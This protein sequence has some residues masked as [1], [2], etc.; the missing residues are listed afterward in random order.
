MNALLDYCIK[1]NFLTAERA[2]ELE[3][4]AQQVKT[5]VYNILSALHILPEEEVWTRAAQSLHCEYINLKKHPIDEQIIKAVSVKIAHYY[6]IV[7]FE[8]DGRT[9]KI[10]INDPTHIT[11]IDDIRMILKKQMNKIR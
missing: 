5:P 3:Q 6:K 8:S 1:N 4:E 2:A 9:L 10:A 7:P 11:V